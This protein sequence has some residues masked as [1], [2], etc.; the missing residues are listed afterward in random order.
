MPILKCKTYIDVYEKKAK[1]RDPNE[2]SGRTGRPD[3]TAF[4]CKSIV[5]RLSTSPSDTLVDIGCGDGTLIRLVSGVVSQAIGVLPTDAEVERVRTLL[6]DIS[7]CQIV[8][9]LAQSTGLPSQ[10]ANKVICNGVLILLT[11]SEVED[12]LRKIVRISKAGACVFIGEVPYLNEQEGKNYGDSIL[13]WL[14]WVLRNHGPTQFIIRLGQTLTAL[15][16]KEPLI[17]APKV[18]FFVDPEAFV[19]TARSCGLVEKAHFR[20]RELTHAGEEC[21]SKTRWDYIFEKGEG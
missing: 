10:V 16:S 19:R 18:H 8:R 15:F 12:A 5:S 4:V 17:V 6:N 20:H 14:W 1:S 9:G 13:L 7:N 21:D 3:L 2:L 11:D